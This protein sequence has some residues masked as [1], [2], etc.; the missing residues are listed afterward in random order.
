M[1]CFDSIV[2][3]SKEDVT[4]VVASCYIFL[5][6]IVSQDQLCMNIMTTKAVGE[7]KTQS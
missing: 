4:V 6:Y 5:L 2:I 1:K 7:R 3:R